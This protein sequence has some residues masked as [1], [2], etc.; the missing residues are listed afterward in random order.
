VG[1]GLWNAPVAETL[2]EAAIYLGGVAIYLRATRPRDRVG[3]LSAWIFAGFV[4][5]I[6]LASA[7]SPP[8]AM[9]ALAWSA[10]LLPWP[11]LL[12]AR[13]FDGHR[14]PRNIVPWQAVRATRRPRA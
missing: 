2:L 1:L 5:L 3:R 12:W 6:H 10:A 7:V 4:P 13:W 9:P 14:D 8:P 11:L